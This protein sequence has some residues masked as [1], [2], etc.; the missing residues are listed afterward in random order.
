MIAQHENSIASRGECHFSDG[1]TESITHCTRYSDTTMKFVTESGEY[2]YSH[3]FEPVPIY[4]YPDKVVRTI[5][6]PRHRFYR[7]NDPL[8]DNEP[9]V[10]DIDY[11]KLFREGLK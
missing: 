5:N 1:R 4:V 7:L 3:W 6:I 8:N 11:I 10:V 2:M 9:Y